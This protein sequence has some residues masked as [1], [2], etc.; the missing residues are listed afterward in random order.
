MFV[1]TELR[2]LIEFKKLCN[3]QRK[4]QVSLEHKQNKTYKQT[5]QHKKTT[6]GTY[7]YSVMKT[8]TCINDSINR[9]VIIITILNFLYYNAI[10]EKYTLA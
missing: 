4:R 5:N 9:Y 7:L 10:D 2:F 3:G 1:K 8:N 6:E